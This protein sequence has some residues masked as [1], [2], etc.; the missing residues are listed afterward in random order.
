MGS[1]S[2]RDRRSLLLPRLSIRQSLRPVARFV[3]ARRMVW[4]HHLTLALP[5]GCGVPPVCRCVQSRGRAWGG[6]SRATQPEAPF[7][8]LV[9]EHR[10]ERALLGLALRGLPAGRPRAMASRSSGSLW[11]VPRL[12]PLSSAVCLRRLCRRLWLHWRQLDP[13]PSG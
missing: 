13:P 7:L 5:S 10:G 1:L 8:Q 4:A 9:S 3:L 11:H 12:G 2:A 6:F